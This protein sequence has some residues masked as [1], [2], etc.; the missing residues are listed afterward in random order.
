MRRAVLPAIVALLVLPLLAGSPAAATP[1]HDGT[2]FDVEI[3][4]DGD[5]VWTITTSY[6]LENDSD[7]TAFDRVR[8]DH[9]SGAETVPDP[10]LFRAAIEQVE[11]ETDREMQIADVNRNSTVR[12]AENGSVGV[13]RLRFTWTDFA[14]VTE[15]RVA[16]ETA[17]TGGWFGDLGANQSLLIEPPDGYRPLTATPSTDIVSGGLHWDG[18]QTFGSGEPVV[19]FEAFETGPPWLDRVLSPMT[20][21]LGG[22]ILGAVLLLAWR[23]GYLEADEER[24]EGDH[25]P[26]S[27]TDDSGAGPA[28]GAGEPATETEAAADPGLLSD[29]ERVER[30]LREN[31]GRM[32]QARIVEETRWSNAKVSQLLSKMAEEGRVEKL[33]IGRENLISLPEEE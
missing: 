25:E 15:D 11:A 32:K 2:T 14:V 1:V 4:G 23:R 6:R 5:A 30:L 20:G 21:V 16:V 7:R 19:V 9:D 28:E 26:A 10:D 27:G 8:A 3:Q 22:A 31:D 12:E 24:S 18:P 17:F 13:L 29:E 33:R